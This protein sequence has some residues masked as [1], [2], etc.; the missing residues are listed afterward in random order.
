MDGALPSD[1]PVADLRAAMAA[2]FE[3][4]RAMPKSAYVS[5]EFLALERERIFAREWVCAGRSSR[6]AEPGDY[7]TLE[8]A[9]EPVIVLRDRDGALRAMSNVCRHRMCTLLEGEG[10]VRTLVCPYHAWTYN[11]D[12][13]P[14]RRARHDPQRG[15]PPR[16]LS[17]C[18]RSAARS[19]RAGSCSRST[20]TR[21]P[22]PRG[23]PTLDPMIG[24]YG[25]ARLR[26]ALPRA[27]RW[28]TNW[29]VLAENFMESYHLPVCHAGTIGGT[30]GSRRWTARRACP[31]STGTRSSR[32]TP[33]RS[34]SRT[35][36]TRGSQ[37]DDRRRTW[38]IAVYPLAPHHA[39]ARLLLVSLAHARR[40]GR[41]RRA[42]RRRPVARVDR[43]PRRRG[44]HGDAEGAPRR[45]Q[46]RGQGTA[47]SGSGAASPR[48]WARRARCRTW[49][50]RTGT[51]PTGSCR[52]WTHERGADVDTL[53]VGG[54]QAGL[55]MSE[56]LARAR[57]A[58]PRPR[59]A[60]HRRAL[61]LRALGFAG[62]QR[63]GLA[64]PLPAAWSSPAST[65]TASPRATSIVRYFEAY[66][67]RIARAGPLRRRGAGGAPAAGGPGFRVE[68]SAG[69]D[70][71]RAMS[72]P[73][74]AR[75]RGR[76]SRR[77]YPRRPASC[78]ST[79]PPTATRA[80]CPR[81]RCWWSARARPARRSPTSCCAPGGGC[82]CRSGPHD[83]PPR[84]YRGRDFCWWLGVLGK[85]DAHAPAPGTEHVTIAVSG[86]GAGRP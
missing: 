37:G 11:L 71:R 63:P 21:A 15:L 25:M 17:A 3:R 86:A 14:A 75:S 58:P 19:G 38:L 39:D 28:D 40:A 1:D 36:S 2:P 83:R 85:W 35:P 47:P 44:A 18:R 68:T 27:F 67:D 77:S 66:A 60:P 78:S 55:A 5:P 29:K 41:G 81:A 64:R 84:A 9:G 72:S 61:A 73:R 26:G 80:S 10:H 51:S 76:W 13:T 79:P 74:P 8:V 53:V 34:R 69:A 24:D 59:A 7:L 48:A 12:G 31:P 50:G 62:G 20:P 23:S 65:P 16:R 56:H 43:R 70:P 57:R 42:V 54:G 45:G 33:C 49:S 4:A 52:G 30:V 22:W 32:T 6:L 82:S 46:R